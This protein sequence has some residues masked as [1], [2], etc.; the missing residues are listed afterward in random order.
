MGVTLG[1]N[2]RGTFWF[3]M[4]QRLGVALHACG[5]AEREHLPLVLGIR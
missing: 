5:L 1:G 3:P 2:E 4:D